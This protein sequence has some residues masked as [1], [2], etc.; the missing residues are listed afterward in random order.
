MDLSA[1]L[2]RGLTDHLALVERAVAQVVERVANDESSVAGDETP[3]ERIAVALGNRL[4]RLVF[5][6]ESA[7]ARY[8]ELVERNIALASAL[9]ACDCWGEQADCPIC[10][11][12]GG[13]GWL[14]PDGQL[15]ARYVRPVVRTPV[16][17]G[18]HNNN[19]HHID[20]ENTHD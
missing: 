20:K 4:A 9:G 8:D 17:P 13:P 19:H 7:S 15:F 2:G 3:A 10:D 11:G 14:P 6:E 18:G 5:D 12:E 16:Q 1:L